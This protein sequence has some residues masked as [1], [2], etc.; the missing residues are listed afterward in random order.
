MS[1]AWALAVWLAVSHGDVIKAIVADALGL[2]L[3]SFQRIV[4]DPGSLSVVTYTSDRAFVQTTNS[5]AGSLAHLGQKS[6]RRRRT[7]ADAVV[8][9]GAGPTSGNRS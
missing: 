5:V 6:R 4:V 7:S 3:D 8:G 9:G 2:H 1:R